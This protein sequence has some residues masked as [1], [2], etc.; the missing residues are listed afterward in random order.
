[1]SSVC[2]FEPNCAM[3]CRRSDYP[4]YH[5][6]AGS[7]RHENSATTAHLTRVRK[8]QSKNEADLK[9]GK[10]SNA[11]NDRLGLVW[12]SFSEFIFCCGKQ[13]NKSRC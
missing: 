3:L 12:S 6:H 10:S 1:M 4:A 5:A 13:L 7:C 9:R 11:P 8:V 2:C